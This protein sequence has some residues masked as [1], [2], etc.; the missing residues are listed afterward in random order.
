MHTGIWYY[1]HCGESYLKKFEAEASFL[2]K[3]M[4]VRFRASSSSKDIFFSFFGRG[5]GG[6]GASTRG[7]F[8]LHYSLQSALCLLHQQRTTQFE[9][10]QLCMGL[11]YWTTSLERFLYCRWVKISLYRE[12]QALSAFC[13]NTELWQNMLTFAQCKKPK[14]L[15]WS[16]LF[17]SGWLWSVSV[18]LF[19]MYVEG[20]QYT[21]C[22]KIVI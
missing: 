11:C 14:K 9:R 8:M 2:A 1:D 7:N 3:W 6:A 19:C 12:N 13:G 18:C 5:G 15:K 21:T 17:L 4:T 16:S 22:K 10:M 20:W